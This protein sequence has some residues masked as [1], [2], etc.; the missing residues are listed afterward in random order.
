MPDSAIRTIGKHLTYKY[1][2][3]QT[4]IT[5]N[6]WG[7]IFAKGI[8]GRHLGAPLGIDDVVY[9]KQAWSTKTVQAKYPHKA[10]NQMNLISGRNDVGFSFG[11]DNPRDDIEKTGTQVLG[12]Y[13]ER[14][15]VVKSNYES[16][17]TC[18]LI[19]NMKKLEFSIVEFEAVRFNPNDYYWILNK[20]KNPLG[21]IWGYEKDTN[22]KRF[23]YQ[24]GGT[25]FTIH[26][27]IPTSSQK[28]TIKTPPILDF[29]E[30]MEQI[31]YDDTWVTII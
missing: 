4:D 18:I 2:V 19:R 11:I 22:V 25:Q 8:G 12:I 1:L 3:G 17:R 28:F 20:D 15:G 21:N 16:L 23:T 5:G 29:E 7:D 30:T 10:G 31:K 24:P 26:Y 9:D 13:N 14:L 6:D 27:S